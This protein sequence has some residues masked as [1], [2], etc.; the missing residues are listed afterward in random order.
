VKIVC[1]SLPL[2]FP[3]SFDGATAINRFRGAAMR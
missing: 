2:V 1:E 3:H